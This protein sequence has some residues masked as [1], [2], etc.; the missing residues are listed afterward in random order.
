MNFAQASKEKSPNKKKHDYS[1]F[2]FE[3]GSFELDPVD[4]S[5]GLTSIPEG[6]RFNGKFAQN[7]SPMTSFVI[8]GDTSEANTASA[9][10]AN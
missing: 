3:S 1:G 10:N 6:S 2:N 9:A 4:N 8:K 7:A 5:P